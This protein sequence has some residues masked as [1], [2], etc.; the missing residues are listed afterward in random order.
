MNGSGSG[1]SD[2]HQVDPLRSLVTRVRQRLHVLPD[3][4]VELFRLVLHHVARMLQRDE[5]G[6]YVI[7]TGEAH[8]VRDFLTAA[9]GELDLDW[10]DYVTLDPS[11]HR[12]AEVDRLVGDAS[13]ARAELGWTPSIDFLGLVKRMVASDLELARR[14]LAAGGNP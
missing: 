5:P 7:A 9:F 1:L 11:L 13:K 3:V 14:E 4:A 6:D 10:E 2:T 12:P 8:T